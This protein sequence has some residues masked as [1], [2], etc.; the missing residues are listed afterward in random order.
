MPFLQIKLSA[1][2]LV[3][4]ACGRVATCTVICICVVVLRNIKVSHS[5]LT[6][7]GDNLPLC[8]EQPAD[9]GITA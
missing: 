8:F 9:P 1:C 3:K 7:L 4:A 2:T 6:V 5:C